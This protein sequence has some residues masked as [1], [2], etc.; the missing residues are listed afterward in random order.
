MS[1]RALIQ[2]V[3]DKDRKMG[4]ILDA[5]HKLLANFTYLLY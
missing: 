5:L 1:Q 4:G 3:K 2:L